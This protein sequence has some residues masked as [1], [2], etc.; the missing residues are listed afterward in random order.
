MIRRLLK[1]LRVLAPV[2]ILGAVGAVAAVHWSQFATLCIL[3]LVALASGVQVFGH[4]HAHRRMDWLL[5]QPLT[6]SGLWLQKTAALALFMVLF[7]LLTLALGMLSEGVRQSS[8]GE[9]DYLNTATPGRIHLPGPDGTPPIGEFIYTKDYRRLARA[10]HGRLVGEAL[11]LS[12]AWMSRVLNQPVVIDT[13]VAQGAFAVRVLPHALLVLCRESLF[14]LLLL[15]GAA[16]SG[17]WMGLWIRQSHTA[18]WAALVTMGGFLLLWSAFVPNPFGYGGV[19][20]YPSLLGM[21]GLPALTWGI[22]AL[23]GSFVC[24]QRLEV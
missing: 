23:V 12:T 14:F 16:C 22:C 20:D 1:D 18:F 8:D 15:T 4:E 9:E 3:C 7:L 19:A 2:G 10:V 5:A 17:F 24:I 6:R 21:A 13:A 11:V